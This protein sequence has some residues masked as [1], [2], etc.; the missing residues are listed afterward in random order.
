MITSTV[1]P[2]NV[3]LQCMRRPFSLPLTHR[4][5]SVCFASAS[6]ALS[7]A[8]PSAKITLTRSPLQQTRTQEQQNELEAYFRHISSSALKDCPAIDHL[9][10]A[11]IQLPTAYMASPADT[12]AIVQNIVR[13]SN[14]SRC[15]EIGVY[16]GKL[17][18]KATG[19]LCCG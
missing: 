14:A 19:A 10:Q 8:A 18:C 4:R 2:A 7:A 17:S 5:S 6:S 1:Q 15:I 16:T 13:L 9:L 3:C 12:L 11:T